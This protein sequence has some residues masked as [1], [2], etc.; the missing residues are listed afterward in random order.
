MITTVHGNVMPLA[1]TRN[2]FRTSQG[3]WNSCWLLHRLPTC[4]N[5]KAERYWA[6]L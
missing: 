1:A 3:V 4:I 6:L 5:C 2:S